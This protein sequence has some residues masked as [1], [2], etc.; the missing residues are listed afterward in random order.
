MKISSIPSRLIYSIDVPEVENFSSEFVYNYY[1]SDESIQDY[2]DGK[3]SLVSLTDK[4]NL[5]Q[6]VVLKPGN[7]VA[8]YLNQESRISDL[9]KFPRYVK[10]SWNPPTKMFVS[11]LGEQFSIYKNS[12]Y[13]DSNA[14]TPE[15]LDYLAKEDIP[16]IIKENEFAGSYFTSLESSNGNLSRQIS[17]IFNR[18]NV[19]NDKDL[20]DNYP[21]SIKATINTFNESNSILHSSITA[22]EYQKNGIEFRSQVKNSYLERISS[23]KFKSQ[24]NNNFLH[25]LL[26][27]ASGTIHPINKSLSR[28]SAYAKNVAKLNPSYK[29]TGE[30]YKASIPYHTTYQSSLKSQMDDKPYY[31]K[32]VGYVIDKVEV[33]PDGKIRTFDPIV[34]KGG[35]SNNYIDFQIR[36]GAIYFYSIRS[37]M[38]V[39]Y[40]AIDNK[41]LTFTE[42][43]SYIASS[44]TTISVETIENIAPPPPNNVRIIWDYDRVNQNTTIFDHA[45]NMPFPNTGTRGSLFITWSMPVNSQ[46]DIKKFQVFRRKSVNESFELIKVYDFDKSFSKF[47]SLEDNIDPKL[48][49]I[50]D[51]AYFYYYDDDFY[52]NSEYIYAIASVDA[53]GLTSNY[54][55]QFKVTFDKF[56]NKLKT[57]LISIAGSP[58][59][60]PNMYLEKDLF[61]DTMKVSN[62][63][64]MH[65]YVNPDCIDVTTR[66]GNVENIL[67]LNDNEQIS[68]KYLVN[69]INV[70]VQKSRQLNI[71]L[72]K[73]KYD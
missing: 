63:N 16:N 58:K 8:G 5:E 69:I 26:T 57:T 13:D 60:Y 48:I 44:D 23:T 52:K 70:D 28:F 61:V 3:E 42:V 64:T 68:S 37:I 43:S 66:D 11:A 38:D 32:I 31:Y 33:F 39:T 36:Y 20:R 71:K 67:M 51:Y 18:V 59:Q 35:R 46:M 27:Q 40:T 54:S 47:S 15:V 45:N 17:S 29:I 25:D 62:K 53:H 12:N 73:K 41:T 65:V 49:E 9:K 14:F 55:E 10:L 1:V 22:I 30:E 2:R 7:E 21:S 50:T 4:M 6:Q 56:E 72:I 19:S 34:L 24:I